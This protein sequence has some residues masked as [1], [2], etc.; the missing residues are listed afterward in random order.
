MSK[1]NSDILQS[2]GDR[3]EEYQRLKRVAEIVQAHPEWL[4]EEPE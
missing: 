1:T 2:L 4:E 3:Y